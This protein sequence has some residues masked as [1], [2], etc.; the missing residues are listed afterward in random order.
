MNLRGRIL[1]HVNGTAQAPLRE[2]AESTCGVVFSG[3]RASDNRSEFTRN[4]NSKVPTIIDPA[5]YEDYRATPD[6]PLGRGT[7]PAL[8]DLPAQR[9]AAAEE[10]SLH[11]SLTPTRYLPCT[12][13]GEAALG[14]AVAWR[15]KTEDPSLILAVPVDARWIDHRRSRLVRILNETRSPKAI[16]L[17]HTGN[18]V[19]SQERARGLREI[20]LRCE[21][22]ALLRTDLAAFEAMVH[23]AA[24]ASIGD[25]SSVRYASLPGSHGWSNNDDSSPN[26]LHHTMLDYFRGSTLAT[27]FRDTPQECTC[28]A[29]STWAEKS[30]RNSGGRQ[31]STFTD[32]SDTSDAHAHNLAVWSHL[33]SLVHGQPTLDQQR[34]YW[35]RMCANAVDVFK[36]LDDK[37]SGR[38][39]VFQTP[40][41]LEV[42]SKQGD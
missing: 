11:F 33:W 15:K 3:A 9:T 39:K 28:S 24:F 21:N 5:V 22:T 10:P 14:N 36:H 7:D 17:C 34:D 18:P 30:G 12:D 37:Y 1:L 38:A 20:F 19:R 27:Y 6:Q 8:M 25:R 42:W 31:L 40:G 23:G 4:T 29:C 41:Y 13:E 2:V 26:V 16:I 32:S 35:R